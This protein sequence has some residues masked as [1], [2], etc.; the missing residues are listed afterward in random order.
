MTD[1]TGDVRPPKI[2]VQ[3]D[4]TATIRRLNDAFRKSEAGG[5]AAVT[6]GIKALG[7]DALATI[8]VAVRDYDGF[9]ADNDPYGEHDMGTLFHAGERVFWKIDY[10]DNELLYG[11]PDPADPTVTTRVLTIMLSSE[12]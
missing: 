8:V 12:Y 2:G 6:P 4:R 7:M 1:L 9:S 10:Y 3:A 11:S 5:I